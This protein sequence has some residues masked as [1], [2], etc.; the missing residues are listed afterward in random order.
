MSIAIDLQEWQ[1]AAPMTHAQL[2]GV[3][4]PRDDITQ[5]LIQV[6][7]EKKRLKVLELRQG[8]SLEASS[9]VGRIAL[10]ELQ[11][12]IRPKIK[13]LPLLHLLQYTYGLRQ[14]DLLSIAGFE[15]ESLTFQDLLIHQLLADPRLE[16]CLINQVLLQG[17]SLA[18]WIANDDQLRTHLL[19]L[20][21]FHLADIAPIKLDQ[22]A[23]KRLHREMNRL[24]AAYAPAIT[25]IEILL[26]S[27]GIS[28][29]ESQP[30]QR[31]PGFLFNMNRFFQELLASFLSD[32]LQDHTIQPQFEIEDMLVYVDNPQHHQAPK[33]RPDYVLKQ[34]GKVVA[35]LDAKYRDLWEKRLPP[36][37]LYQLVMYALS[38]EHCNSA[39]ILYPTTHT[40]ARE[41]KI[42][43]RVPTYDKGYSYVILRPVNLLLL[44]T[45]LSNPEKKIHAEIERERASFARW[46]AFGG[47]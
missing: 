26:A 31:L 7:S 21:Y 44:E 42:E 8:V 30:E 25:L 24:T 27:E 17:V 16:D 37:M 6:L 15:T 41:A 12:T 34:G 9:Y 46:L 45:L 38:Q 36:D 35:I 39:T 2:V 11:I 5:R 4:L 22:Q 47:N 23:L 18:A 33:P 29:D 19:Q 13:M 32:Y 14:L 40:E 20:A 10:G 43:I 3:E 1:A 28:L